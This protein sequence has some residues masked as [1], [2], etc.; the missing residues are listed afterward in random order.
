MFTEE[1]AELAKKSQAGDR[2]ALT[3]LLQLAHTPVY[4]QCR[5][6]LRSDRVAEA[7]TRQILAA[8]PQQLSRLQNPRDF[9][10][11]IGRITA[12][13]CMQ[14]LSRMAPPPEFPGDPP[15][16]NGGHLDELETARLVRKLVDL[17]PEAPRVCLLLYS[18]GWL[19]LRAIAQL[20]GATEAEVLEHLNQAQKTIN[21]QL[22]AY[23]RLGVHFDAIPALSTL[24]RTA[25]YDSRDP[26]AAAVLV[27]E[28]LPRQDLAP[29]H[30]PKV[31]PRLLTAL[32]VTGGLLAL[33][34]A[35][36]LILETR[37]V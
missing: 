23:H 21:S 17:L 24:V 31:S 35:A 22:R 13:R 20:T 25:M 32:A 2:K 7:M 28:I 5:A 29:S 36:I 12:S 8:V 9:E 30:A 4:F 10:K 18:C 6:L 15:V 14:A 1:F 16:L 11:W 19:K 3:A 37:G 27:R 33:L 26:K 34:L